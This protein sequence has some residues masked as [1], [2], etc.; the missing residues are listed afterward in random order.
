MSSAKRIALV[1]MSALPDWEVDDAP[2]VAALEAQGVEVS[3]PAW[4]AEGEDWSGYDVCLLRTTWD[5]QERA[6]EFLKWVE[7]AGAVTRLLN[8]L[9][10]VEWNIQ[11][12]YLRELEE[13][14]ARCIPTRWLKRGDRVS[15]DRL[16]RE[17]G[18]AKGF[19]KPVVGA[20]AR[21]TFRFA[22]DESDLKRVQGEVDRL[23]QTED[24][25]VQP[26]LASVED[27]GEVSAIFF[28]GEFSHGVRKIP[29]AGDYRV[30][31]DWG[32]SDEPWT[33][34]EQQLGEVTKILECV[35]ARCSP[36]ERLLYARLDFLFL[37]DEALGLN[38]AEVIEPSLFFRHSAEAGARLA[39]ALLRRCST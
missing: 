38:E 12:T 35:E 25:M 6:A 4:D 18:W 15:L 23:L 10:V 37:E 11:K 33:P 5:Y 9:R 20:N 29:K 17:A 2:L 22:N 30:Q 26:Y 36:G 28:D 27:Q 19:I 34:T 39:G 1:T 7:H 31:D 14:G 24:L 16:V 8:P 3:R 13:D 32:A 21:E